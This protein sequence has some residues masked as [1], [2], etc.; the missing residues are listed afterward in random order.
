[1]NDIAVRVENMSKLYKIGARQE[2]YENG[3]RICS[4]MEKPL[5]LAFLTFH[6]DQQ[7]DPTDLD[8]TNEIN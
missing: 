1:M 3:I 8:V 5:L 7:K 2:R 4:L 6:T